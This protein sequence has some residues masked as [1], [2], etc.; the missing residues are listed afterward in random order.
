[1]GRPRSTVGKIVSKRFRPRRPTVISI[2]GVERDLIDRIE[3]MLDSGELADSPARRRDVAFHRKRLGM[4][5][6]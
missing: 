5:V 3:S 1:M 4:K 6:R 2:A